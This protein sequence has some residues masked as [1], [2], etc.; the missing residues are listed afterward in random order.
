MNPPRHLVAVALVALLIAMSDAAPALPLW[1]GEGARF[2]AHPKGCLN[3]WVYASGEGW[4]R[5]ELVPDGSV[6]PIAAH[7]FGHLHSVSLGG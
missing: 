7:D 6:L 2:V 1:L 4:W 5:R 3:G